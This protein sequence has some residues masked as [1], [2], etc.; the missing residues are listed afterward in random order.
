M[1]RKII[2]QDKKFINVL[3]EL[4]FNE[5]EALIYFTLLKE[6]NRGATVNELTH[7]VHDVFNRTTIYS[8]I[9][10]LIRLGCVEDTGPSKGARKATKFRAIKASEYF[11]KLIL[12]KQNEVKKIIDLK[13]KFSD[14]LDVIYQNGMEYSIDELDPEIQVY[15]KPL[16]EKGWKIKS[17]LV[18]KDVPPFDY[19][20]YDCMLYSP[21][22]KVMLENSFHLFRFKHEIEND[23]N[24]LELFIHALKMKTEEIIGY[25]SDLSDYYFEESK[26]T[27]FGRNLPALVLK[28]KVED[29]LNSEYFSGQNEML[30]T[31]RS[32]KSTDYVEIWKSITFP[33]KKDIYFLWAESYKILQEMVETIFITINIP[34]SKN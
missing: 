28:V 16:V 30:N 15:L 19:D 13:E 3:E 31:F 1:S 22:A 4:G 9:N 18:K 17:Y 26:L 25:Y 24:T 6:G 20:V 29:I 5:N 11:D 10:K 33:I 27:F 21:D 12:D 7:E 14:Y 23:K 8:I 2:G 32:L 34:L